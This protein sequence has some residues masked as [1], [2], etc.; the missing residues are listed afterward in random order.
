MRNLNV[1]LSI[2]PSYDELPSFE[3]SSEINDAH[4][5]IDA[6]MANI[7]NEQPEDHQENLHDDERE[8]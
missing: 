7:A 6:I 5:P 8:E 4:D 2:S 3:P 1:E